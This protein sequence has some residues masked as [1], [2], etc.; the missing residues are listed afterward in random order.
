MIQCDLCMLSESIWFDPSWFDSDR[1]CSSRFNSFRFQVGVIWFCVIWSDKFFMWVECTWFDWFGLI[2]CAS[3][4][5]DF[6][7]ATQLNVAQIDLIPFDAIWTHSIWF[8]PIQPLWVWLYVIPVFVLVF[9][10]WCVLVQCDLGWF[11]VMCLYTLR[12]GLIGS[13]H[14]EVW[15]Y[16]IRSF[17]TSWCDSIW[18]T[19][20]WLSVIRSR[21]DSC[22]WM[23]FGL[24]RFNSRF[25]FY[26]IWFVSSVSMHIRFMLI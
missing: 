26:S 13:L 15:F 25:V 24:T 14:D 17:D 2:Q 18:F 10:I 1:V 12:C 8:C 4:W 20:L 23:S 7:E 16:L 22:D 21:Y 9:L 6:F 11:E 19:L 5:S 3:M